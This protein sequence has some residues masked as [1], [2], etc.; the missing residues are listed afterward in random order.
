MAWNLKLLKPSVSNNVR[1][2]IENHMARNCLEAHIS[3]VMISSPLEQVNLQLVLD[4]WLEQSGQPSN[5]FGYSLA[6]Y[7]FEKSS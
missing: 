7:T 4:K 2:R 5:L 3:S 6:Q 1:E